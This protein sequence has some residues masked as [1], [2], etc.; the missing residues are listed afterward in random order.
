MDPFLFTQSV[1]EQNMRD[2]PVRVRSKF[3]CATQGLIPLQR[4]YG[5]K[6]GTAKPTDT[7]TA[8]EKPKRA[9]TAYNIFFKM[10]QEKLNAARRNGERV[11]NTAAAISIH[12]KKLPP[13]KRSFYFQLAAEDKFRYYQEKNAY[14]NFLMLQRKKSEKVKSEEENA[15]ETFEGATSEDAETADAVNN[16]VPEDW[17]LPE[18]TFASEAAN[19]DSIPT[20]SRHAIALLAS[21]L[22]QASIDFII[23]VLK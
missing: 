6:L 15:L 8:M 1:I 7:Q 3:A 9:R 21:K 20:Y 17:R 22:D 19:Q 2:E 18:Y 11:D 12:W 23:K 5:N 10:Q 14:E 13:N 16:M 4:S